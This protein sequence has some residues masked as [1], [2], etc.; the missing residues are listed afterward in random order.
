MCVLQMCE[1]FNLRVARYNHVDYVCTTYIF[2]F[3]WCV[4]FRFKLD[5][6]PSMVVQHTPQFF[7]VHADSSPHLENYKLCGNE[8]RDRSLITETQL[9]AIRERQC[10][11]PA[12]SMRNSER[13]YTFTCTFEIMQQITGR[14]TCTKTSR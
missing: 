2:I 10:H 5:F 1:M 6:Y 11:M 3:G 9:I 8:K 4:V 7:H 13:K 14:G 12:Q